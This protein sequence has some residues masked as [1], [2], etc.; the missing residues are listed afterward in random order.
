ML[1]LIEEHPP[2]QIQDAEYKRLLGLPPDFAMEGRIGELARWARE[3]YA[4]RGEPW[5]SVRQV[6]AVGIRDG[7]VE[8]EGAVLE[9][10]KLRELLEQAEAHSAVVVALGAGPSARAHDTVTALSVALLIE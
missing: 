6:E 7:R 2:I 1:R 4:E 3:W 8:I 9:S 5:V 10:D